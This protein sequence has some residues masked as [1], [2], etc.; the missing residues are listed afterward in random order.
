MI[1]LPHAHY[2]AALALYREH[3]AFFPLIAAVLAGEQDG[4]VHADRTEDP[5]QVFVQHAFGFAQMFGAVVP[6]FEE[7]IRRYLLVDKAFSCD[8]VRLYTPRCPE[9]LAAPDLANIRSWRQRFRHD[10]ASRPDS[11]A[12]HGKGLELVYADAR[13]VATIDAAFG[14]VRRFWRDESDFVAKSGAVLALVNG[15]PAA[16]CYAAATV[17]GKAEIDVM[18]LPAHR[19]L[20]LGKTVV[21]AFNERAIASDVLPLWDCFTNNAA[22]MSLCRASGFIPTGDPYP[23]F[24]INR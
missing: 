24:T 15:E 13:H 17:D 6:A 18:T 14:V 20:G 10:R 8:K 2:P 23:F 9:F 11:P 16:L 3:K 22:S 12:Q 4:V 1:Q 7:S 5:A 21:A 19:Q